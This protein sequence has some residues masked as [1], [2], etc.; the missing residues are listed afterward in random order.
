MKTLLPGLLLIAVMGCS[1]EQTSWPKKKFVAEEWAKTAES[2]RYPFARDI[3][4]SH[5]LVGKSA[6]EVKQLLGAPS[7]ESEADHYF[8]YIIKVGGDGFNQVY[9]L[10]VKVSPVTGKVESAIVRG[11]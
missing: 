7:S 5:V 6:S 8:T 4:E 2:E 3:V 1:S 10:D 11:D 9:V